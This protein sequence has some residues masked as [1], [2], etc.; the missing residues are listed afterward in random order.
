MMTSQDA[1]LEAVRQKVQE[2][3][4]EDTS[5]HDY[6]HMIR[7]EKLAKRIAIAEGAAVF[8]CQLAALVHDMID[9]KLVLDTRQALSEL[10]LTLRDLGVTEPLLE[11]VLAIITRISFKGGK[12]NGKLSL[13]GQVVQDADRLDAIGA[14]GIARTMAFSGSC[15]RLIHAPAMQPREN[16]TEATYRQGKE[17][18]MMP[19][20]EKL[21]KLK[22]LMNTPTGRALALERHRF[23][24]SYLEQFQAEWE[25][26][27]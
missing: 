19:I 25:G 24:E 3:F 20:H 9:D 23:L 1:I 8:T 4:A 7:V 2:R 26:V 15:G 11:E 21:L 12:T 17:T 18:A 27:R 13:E 5:G 16:L 10:T 22:D 14:I 6:W